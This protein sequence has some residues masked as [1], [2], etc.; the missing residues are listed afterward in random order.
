MLAPVLIHCPSWEPEGLSSAILI[1][2]RG[3]NELESDGAE[4]PSDGPEPPPGVVG[5]VKLIGTELCPPALFPDC[6]T[7]S[8]YLWHVVESTFWQLRSPSRFMVPVAGGSV[9]ERE[10]PVYWT[11]A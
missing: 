9:S 6:S 4:P 11:P 7:S 3:Y 10:G 1:R 8:L 2:S 5:P